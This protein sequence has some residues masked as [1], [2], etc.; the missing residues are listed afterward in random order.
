MALWCQ[1]HIDIESHCGFGGFFGLTRVQRICEGSAKDLRFTALVMVY[2]TTRS[3][4]GVSLK[5]SMEIQLISCVRWATW[6]RSSGSLPIGFRILCDLT[7]CC[8]LFNSK[9]YLAQFC[10][11]LLPKPAQCKAATAPSILVT[12]LDLIKLIKP[13]SVDLSF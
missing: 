2:L 11:L 6:A 7:F 12:S 9:E 8:P 1:S 13:F 5:H 4:L 3:T 10:F